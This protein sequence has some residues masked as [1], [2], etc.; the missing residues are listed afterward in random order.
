[1]PPSDP[2]I[3]FTKT[4]HTDTYPFIQP[5]SS[6]SLS[7]KTVFITGAS[8]GI[9]RALT[10]S[11]T[12]SGVSALA[13]AARSSLNSLLTEI[14]DVA[15]TAGVPVPKVFTY[16]MDVAE[17]AAIEECA[18]Q[19]AKD[20]AGRLDI[21]INNAGYLESAKPIAE[22]DPD[23]WWKTWTVNMRG[24]Y[25]VTRALLPLMLKGGDK[26]IVNL[27]SVGALRP[28]PGM[29]GYQTTKVAV[30]RFTEYIEA[31]Y[32]NQGVLALAVHPGGVMTELA[33][34]MPKETHGRE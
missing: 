18:A 29:S 13:L 9:G 31:E 12:R 11:Y 15:K 6:S 20:L 5:T 33:A 30:C 28:R 21:L 25:L 26:T 16:T 1:M 10:L 32:G 2:R 19:T 14:K 3:S 27:S 17:R 4:Y 7:G 8:K 24:T 23:E 22:S 34:N